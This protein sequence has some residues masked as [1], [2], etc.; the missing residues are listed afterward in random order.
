MHETVIA[1]NIIKEADKHGKVKEITLEI[2]EGAHVPGS[3]LIATLQRLKPN[4]KIHW[5]EI[6]SHVSCSCGYAGRPTILERGHD[7]FLYECPE[8]GEVPDLAAGKDIKI[9]KVTV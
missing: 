3:D 8:C 1:Q 2:G 6:P 5:K 4:W 9:V 7:S